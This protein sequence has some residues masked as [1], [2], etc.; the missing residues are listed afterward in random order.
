MEQR[1]PE[2]FSARRHRLTGSNVGAAL[3]LNPW[4]TPDDLIRQMVRAYHDAPAEF[5][6]NVAT[7]Y[8][9]LH[10]P[11]A[12]MEY[13]GKTGN[14]PIECGFFVHPIHEWLGA[15]PDALI[16]EDGGLEVKCPFSQRNKAVPEFKT[17][18]EQEH[19]YAQMQVEMA[20]AGRDWFDFYQWAPKGDSLERVYFDPGWWSQNLP[21]MQAF[22]ERYLSELDNPAHLEPLAVEVNTFAARSL[23]EEYDDLSETIGNAEARKKEIMAE[24]VKMAKDRNAIIHGR[25]L[26]KIERKGNIQYAKVPELQG[27]DL[28][29]YRAKPSEFWKLS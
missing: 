17:A 5:V 27:L 3:G 10:E 12:I 13:M 11:L 18:A 23:I 24:L 14:H 7:E 22:Y 26:T 8:G 25:K 28:E 6:G 16:D 29:P 15:S 2:W 4:K 1:T 20:C 9:Q 21:A 19:Y